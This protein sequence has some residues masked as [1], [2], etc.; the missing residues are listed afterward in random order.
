MGK[1]SILYGSY[2][3]KD[4]IYRESIE[5][6]EKISIYRGKDRIYG[7]NIDFIWIYWKKDRIYRESIEFIEKVSNL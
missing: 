1:I 4:R 2:W 6:I 3:K 7:E 5:F